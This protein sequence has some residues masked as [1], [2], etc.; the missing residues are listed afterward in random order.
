MPY[1]ANCD[2]KAACRA[3]TSIPLAVPCQREI[4]DTIADCPVLVPML[5][6]HPLVYRRTE[7]YAR[8]LLKE[9]DHVI[10]TWCSKCVEE[11]ESECAKC[12]EEAENARTD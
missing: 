2:H 5:C 9:G 8:S 3:N 6:G 10:S 4:A 11:A 1:R 7:E 12:E